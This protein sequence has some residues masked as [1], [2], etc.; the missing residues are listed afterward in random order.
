MDCINKK[1]TSLKYADFHTEIPVSREKNSNSSPTKKISPVDFYPKIPVGRE[2]IVIRVQ[3]QK[4]LS[5]FVTVNIT[6]LSKEFNTSS[7]I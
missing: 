2:K 1:L 3:Q 5:L 7:R 6:K 4:S